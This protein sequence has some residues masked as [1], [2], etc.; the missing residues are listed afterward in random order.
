MCFCYPFYHY[1]P[2]I[3]VYGKRCNRHI[4]WPR[5]KFLI[6]KKH[7]DEQ[8]IN[9]LSVIFHILRYSD[10]LEDFQPFSF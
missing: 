6:V 9:I 2:K 10:I 5:L 4:F 3:R 7:T 1:R 8:V